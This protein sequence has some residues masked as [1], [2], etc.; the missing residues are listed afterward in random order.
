VALVNPE[1]FPWCLANTPGA[2][3]ARRFSITGSNAARLGDDALAPAWSAV[4]THP[5]RGSVEQVFVVSVSFGHAPGTP[6]LE[7]RRLVSGP[8]D[9]SVVCDCDVLLA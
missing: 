3:I 7:A 8:D 5:A 6:Q 9:A 1:L 2:A 4:G